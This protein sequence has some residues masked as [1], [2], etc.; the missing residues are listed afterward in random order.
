[1]GQQPSCHERLLPRKPPGLAHVWGRFFQLV[2]SMAH[3]YPGPEPGTRAAHS[4]RGLYSCPGTLTLVL[5][6]L[7]GAKHRAEAVNAAASLGPEVTGVSG[8]L[9][10]VLAPQTGLA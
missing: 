7:V 3:T 5:S 2:S 1:M 8:C 10:C 9:L 6:T 4:R